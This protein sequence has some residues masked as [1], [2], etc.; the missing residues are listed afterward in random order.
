M[1]QIDQ[2]VINFFSLEEFAIKRILVKVFGW[3][4]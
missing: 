2:I 4:Y 3:K 1:G